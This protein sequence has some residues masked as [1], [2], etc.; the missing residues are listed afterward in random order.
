[1]VRSVSALLCNRFTQLEPRDKCGYLSRPASYGFHRVGVVAERE[2]IEPAQLEE[3]YESFESEDP[4]ERRLTCRFYRQDPAALLG[5]YGETS[6]PNVVEHE[7]S[8]RT[9]SPNAHVTGLVRWLLWAAASGPD[10][11][12]DQ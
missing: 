12:S 9:H 8:L 1:M 4:L 11:A 5:I 2:K 10:T 7:A 6:L 3:R